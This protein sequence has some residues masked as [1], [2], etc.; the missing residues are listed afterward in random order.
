MSVYD[1]LLRVNNGLLLERAVERA[2]VKLVKGY[3]ENDMLLDGADVYTSQRGIPIAL[4]LIEES[5][6]TIGEA[7]DRSSYVVVVCSD[8]TETDGAHSVRLR[9][10]VN[11]NLYDSDK[12]AQRHERWCAAVR[13]IMSYAA[14]KEET[15]LMVNAL[16]NEVVVCGWEGDSQVPQHNF[17]ENKWMYEET[18]LVQAYLTYSGH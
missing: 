12:E 2:F 3:A 1:G 15:R 6:D 18:F 17:V 7:R 4:G 5:A 10:V 16:Q 11:T 8:F 13:G 9:L 14:L